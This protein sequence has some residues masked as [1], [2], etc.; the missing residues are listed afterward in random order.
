VDYEYKYNIVRVCENASSAYIDAEFYEAEYDKPEDAIKHF[1]S[2][3]EEEQK[4]I[5]GTDY[6]CTFRIEFAKSFK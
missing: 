3:P 5:D 1:E 6:N 2:L 4:K